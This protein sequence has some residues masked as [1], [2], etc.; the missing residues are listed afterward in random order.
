MRTLP[1]IG[2]RLF[3]CLVAAHLVGCMGGYRVQ[4]SVD[5]DGT[6]IDRMIDNEIGLEGEGV[7]SDY[8]IQG[9]Q[10]DL[11]EVERHCFLDASRHRRPDGEVTYYLLFRYTG[12]RYLEIAKRRSLELLIDDHTSCTLLGRGQVKRD[13][14]KLE[15]TSTESYQYEISDR[16]LVRLANAHKVSVV[17]TGSAFDL[18]CY[19]VPNNFE[20]FRKF[21][22][23]FVDWYDG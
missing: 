2:F 4:T 10:M 6:V 9:T 1:Y 15:K 5:A 17:V 18:E 13:E 19:F 11:A 21:V 20:N 3:C 14:N 7:Y 8:A 16:V 23:E 12:P 22:K